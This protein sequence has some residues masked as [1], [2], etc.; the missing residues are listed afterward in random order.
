MPA[1]TG[2]VSWLK[3]EK[4]THHRDACVFVGSSYRKQTGHDIIQEREKKLKE[5]RPS[6]QTSLHSQLCGGFSL[7]NTAVNRMQCFRKRAK[8]LFSRLSESP[9]SERF[10]PL[11][12][13]SKKKS[14]E[15]MFGFETKEK[16]LRLSSTFVYSKPKAQGF[17]FREHQRYATPLQ[18]P[19]SPRLIP[20]GH[21]LAGHPYPP[22]NSWRGDFER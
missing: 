4:L 12:S 15:N 22:K 5:R 9:V 6:E 16:P 21:I 7:H 14:D 13:S 3:R 20:P 2:R 8:G 11:T 18:L 1:A 10:P 19:A 17:S